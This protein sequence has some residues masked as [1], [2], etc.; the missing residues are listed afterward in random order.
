[1]CTKYCAP[2]F[3]CTGQLLVCSTLLSVNVFNTL[4][5]TIKAKIWCP[6]M[7]VKSLV[8]FDSYSFSEHDLVCSTKFNHYS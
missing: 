7:T 6:A 2:P 4:Q 1:M 8:S 3:R 5:V